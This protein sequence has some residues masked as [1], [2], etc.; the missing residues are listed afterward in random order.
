MF[1]TRCRSSVTVLFFTG[2]KAKYAN[3]T[4]LM[5][6]MPNAAGGRPLGDLLS[7]QPRPA[8]LPPALPAMRPAVGN[9]PASLRPLPAKA[10]SLASDGGGQ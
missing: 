9:V 10:A 3:S 8:R 6:A 4:Q 2:Q 7:L 1:A 5:L